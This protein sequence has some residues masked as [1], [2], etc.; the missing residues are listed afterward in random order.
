MEKS[1]KEISCIYSG[2]ISCDRFYDRM[3]KLKKYR[4]GGNSRK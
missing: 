3:C 2:G 1:E 4:Y